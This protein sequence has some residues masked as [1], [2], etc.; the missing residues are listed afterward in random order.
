MIQLFNDMQTLV[1][2]GEIFALATVIDRSGSAPRSTGAKMLVRQ[3]GGIA[4]TVGGGILEANVQALAARVIRERRALVEG[5]QF[6]GRDAASMDAICGGQVEVLVEWVDPGEKQSAEVIAGLHDALQ[7]QHKAWLVT[8]F[9]PQAAAT[10]HA[11]V[12]DNGIIGRLPGE[13]SI[14]NIKSV[15]TPRQMPAGEFT[16]I[17]E[18]LNISGS[19]LIFGAGHVSRSLAEF[20]K[21][22]GFR[23]VII[24]D[25]PEFASRDRFPEAD[26]IIVLENFENLLQR[27]RSMGKVTP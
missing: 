20:T 3:D 6:S 16:V 13:I 26:K 22:V 19:A 8:A 18:P 17:I 25:R 12:D 23:T 4:G 7:G 15:R 1:K 14:E 27:W 10:T 2:K 5:F 24:D 9:D 21:A 11:L